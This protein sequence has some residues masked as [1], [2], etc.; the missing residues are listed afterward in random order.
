MAKICK[1]CEFTIRP[2]HGKK[3]T[4]MGVR[5]AYG[6]KIYDCP[7]CGAHYTSKQYDRLIEAES[8]GA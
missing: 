4:F 1:E 5:G 7:L 2:I 6:V 3:I 8:K